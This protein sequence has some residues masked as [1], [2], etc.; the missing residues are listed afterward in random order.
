MAER[1]YGVKSEIDN[2]NKHCDEKFKAQIL[3]FAELFI[4]NLL[5]SAAYL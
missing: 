3:V 2:K 4:L 5:E 1:R